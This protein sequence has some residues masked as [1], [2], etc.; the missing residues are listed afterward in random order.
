METREL[1]RTGPQ[2][3]VI[4]LGTMTFGG[5]VNP[6]DS[7]PLMDR[8]FDGGINFFDSAEGY[9]ALGRFYHRCGKTGRN[10]PWFLHFI[11]KLS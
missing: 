2:V 10:H 9:G 11:S 1:G 4:C 6:K 7:F 3:S 5:K 8:A